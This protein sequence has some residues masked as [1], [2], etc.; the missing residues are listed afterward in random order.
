MCRDR[1]RVALLRGV[2]LTSALATDGAG[3]V[4]GITACEGVAKGPMDWRPALTGVEGAG[5]GGPRGSVEGVDA[6]RGHAGTSERQEE[7]A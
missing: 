7:A 5:G 4:E 1:L 6:V 3:G 2:V